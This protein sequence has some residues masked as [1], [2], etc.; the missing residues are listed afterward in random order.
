MNRSELKEEAKKSLKGKYNDAVIMLLIVILISAGAAVIGS[1]I[2]T[3]LGLVNKQTFT[4]GTQVLEYQTTGLFTSLLSMTLT[5]FL[6]FGII[7]YF[8][9]ISR[10]KEVNWKDI[11]KRYDLFVYFFVLSLIVSIFTFLW[12]LLFI[13]PGIIAA[14]SYS[15]VYYLKLDNPDLE[16]MDNIKKSKELMKGHKW[17][18]FVLELSFL[19]WI[20]LVPFTCGILAFWLVPYMSVTQCNFYNKLINK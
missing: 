15:L 19:G 1:I 7:E 10:G 11:F 3:S 13:I 6:G 17:E 16:Y 12:S 2:D 14:F 4:I 9:N 8:L 18:Y 5:C 20:I